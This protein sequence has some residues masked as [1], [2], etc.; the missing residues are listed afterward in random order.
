MKS[1]CCTSET[2]QKV[3]SRVWLFAT[4]WTIVHGILQARILE[5]VT[6]PFS[7]GSSQPR[8]RTQVSCIIGRFFISWATREAHS[9]QMFTDRLT[10]IYTMNNSAIKRNQILTYA[11]M[12]ELPEDLMLRKQA[13]HRRANAGWFHWYGIYSCQI[14]GHTKKGGGQGMRRGENEELLFNG[15]RVSDWEAE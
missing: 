11:T 3:L 4:P 12:W 8:E 5:W 2:K 14:C 13:R 7:R 15:N 1:L 9:D 10:T 6:F